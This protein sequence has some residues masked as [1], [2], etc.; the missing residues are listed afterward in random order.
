[1][2]WQNHPCTL[3]LSPWFGFW[4]AVL[5]HDGPSPPECNVDGAPMGAPAGKGNGRWRPYDPEYNKERK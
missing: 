5:T 2:F 1:M 4:S 3:I